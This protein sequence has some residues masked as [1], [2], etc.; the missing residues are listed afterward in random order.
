MRALIALIA[1]LMMAV[2]AIATAQDKNVTDTTLSPQTQTKLHNNGDGTFSRTTTQIFT[3]AT[4]TP[5]IGSATSSGVTP[6]SGTA[7]FAGS[8]ATIGPLIPQLGRVLYVQWTGTWTGSVYVGT[9]TNNCVTV[10]PLTAAG[11]T[12]GS[13]TGN[14][15]EPVDL[16]M[17]AS[18]QYC[19]IATITSGTLNYTVTQ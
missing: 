5:Q 12:W 6:S 9:S 4:S 2:P 13:Y 3:A 10:I 19:A 17:S 16:P 1:M 8:V 15:N 7:T 18:N 11:A 14:A